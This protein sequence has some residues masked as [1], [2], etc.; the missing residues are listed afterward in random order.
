MLTVPL[1]LALLLLSSET[2]GPAPAFPWQ[3]FRTI[4]QEPIVGEVDLCTT[5]GSPLYEDD[6]CALL[7]QAGIGVEDFLQ[8]L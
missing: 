6:L 1:L 7:R 4:A 2:A 8:L 5:P 3:S